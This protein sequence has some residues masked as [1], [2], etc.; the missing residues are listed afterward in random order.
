MFDLIYS[1]GNLQVIIYETFVACSRFDQSRPY[2]ISPSQS[3]LLSV[4]D[5]PYDKICDLRNKQLNSD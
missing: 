4:L 3:S 5:F 2:H 1:D